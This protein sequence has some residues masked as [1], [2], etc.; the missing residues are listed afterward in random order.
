[1]SSMPQL[2]NDI[3]Q[4]ISEKLLFK[5]PPDDKMFNQ[6]D[7][8]SLNA[9][10]LFMYHSVKN[11]RSFL[12]NFTKMKRLELL[13]S[14]DNF[15]INLYKDE[16]LPFNMIN[17]NDF[18]GPYSVSKQLI[19]DLLCAGLLRTSFIRISHA[20]EELPDEILKHLI[21]PKEKHLITLLSINAEN[22]EFCSF[23]ENLIFECSSS[24]VPPIVIERTK[25]ILTK[26]SLD[27][28]STNNFRDNF[29][30]YIQ[31]LLLCCSNLEYLEFE[32]TSNSTSPNDYIINLEA[33]IISIIE[34]LK[35]QHR[36]SKNLKIRIE[37][38]ANFE[39]VLFESISNEHKI[40]TLGNSFVIDEL[41]DDSP[42]FARSIKF[43]DSIGRQHECLFQIFSEKPDLS[44]CMFYRNCAFQFQK[45]FFDR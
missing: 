28:E 15:K 40:F 5:K 17:S 20:L 7:L 12:S 24:K 21:N 29:K 10:T 35:H 27:M 6:M 38:T 8:R 3:L 4:I 37:F 32:C 1:M 36:G 11:M 22:V 43:N 16:S 30:S 19:L 44:D 39:E 41:S 9:Y 25:K 34:D 13:N 31:F 26:C 2:S 14:G 42:Y 23:W 45:I 18:T 33:L